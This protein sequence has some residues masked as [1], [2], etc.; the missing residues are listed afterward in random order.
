MRH[1]PNPLPFLLLGLVLGC[2][3]PALDLEAE[4]A[5]LMERS[6]AWSNVIASGDLE[7]ILEPWAEDAVLL[8]PDSPPLEG[9]A[10]IRNYIEAALQLPGFQ[11]GWEPVS[12]SVARAGDM[13]H[14]LE[15][16]TTTIHDSLGNPLT[17]YGRA[18]TVWRKDPD[19]VWRNVVDIWNATAS[20][21]N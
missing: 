8:P 6:R 11:I 16:T 9:K 21:G 5:A 18:V 13:G 12:V 7:A 14:L 3:P 10:A 4:G 19:G 20:A 17:T 15:R 2:Q 1:C